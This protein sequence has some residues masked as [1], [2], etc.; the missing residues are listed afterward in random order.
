MPA[1]S[2]LWDTPKLQI[3]HVCQVQFIYS[4]YKKNLNSNTCM[5]SGFHL[6]GTLIKGISF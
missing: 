5:Y 4:I 1:H 3:G 6:M 2:V